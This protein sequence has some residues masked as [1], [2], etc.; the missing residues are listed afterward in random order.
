VTPH[1]EQFA[2]D[3]V[4]PPRPGT[5]D[6]VA[7]ASSQRRGR[8]PVR[9]EPD[10]TNTRLLLILG[11][12][13]VLAAAVL[14]VVLWRVF[15]QDD[16]PPPPPGP[17]GPMTFFVGTGE[18]HA[19]VEA[20]LRKAHRGDRIVVRSD[21]REA[22]RIDEHRARTLKGVRIEADER[23]GTIHW[24]PLT[25][26]KPDVQL[27]SFNDVEDFVIK[28]FVFDGENKIQSL[29]GL[30]CNCRNVVFEDV[31]LKGY[32]ETGVHFANC[33]GTAERPV[34]LTK[35]EFTSDKPPIYLEVFK[36]FPNHPSNDHVIVKDDCKFTGST[37]VKVIIDLP[38]GKILDVKLPPVLKR[39]D[40]PRPPRK[41]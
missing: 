19:T 21:I 8:R 13:G 4:A 15:S 41:T 27:I 6:G 31:K 37:S 33:V 35:A 24:R 17:K 34:V 39:E 9:Q 18:E 2:S 26:P 10:G 20:A 28:G 14:V 29:I 23:R 11:T 7:P 38:G 5:G 25:T 16:S 3:T 40:M 36:E 12:V 22:L 30:A 1:W 32:T